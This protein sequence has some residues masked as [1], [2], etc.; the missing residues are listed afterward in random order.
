MTTR[1]HLLQSVSASAALAAI[2][3]AVAAAQTGGVT[4]VPGRDPI[5]DPAQSWA[6][7]RMIAGRPLADTL[8]FGVGYNWFDHLGAGGFY[9]RS[10]SYPLDRQ[11]YPDL[12][13]EEAWGQIRQA[14]DE[15]R[16]GFI[17]FGLPPDAHVAPDGSFRTGTVHLKRLAWLDAWARKNGCTI[18]LDPFLI[19]A[20][21]EFPP[22][23]GLAPAAMCNMAARDNTAYAERFVAPLLRHVV[24]ELALESV[25]YFN[26]VNEPL[27]Y[28]VYQTPRDGPDAYRHYVD[29]Y[30]AMRSALD[31]A[32]VARD[33]LGLVGCD[34]YTQRW[35]F[36]PEQ[37]ARG[38]DIDPFVDVYSIHFYSLRFDTL[39]ASEGSWTRPIV[40]LMEDSARQVRY[41]AERKKR[42]IA[43]EMGTFYYGWRM[44]DPAGVAS[45]DGT[46][47]VA[48]GVVRGMNA[49]LGAFGFWSFMNPNDIDG[50][51]GI[52]GL[53]HD[54]R[55]VRTAHPWGTYGLLSRY[56]RPGSTVYPLSEA[57]G[58]NLVP[59]HGTALVAPTGEKTI[60]L[61]HDEPTKRCRVDLVLPEPLRAARWERLTTDRVRVHQRLPPLE[62]KDPA[63]PQVVLNPFSLTVLTA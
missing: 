24:K 4:P 58:R 9:A 20:A 35:L 49:G 11:I 16:P 41:C 40:D 34:T 25:R 54:R 31:R 14:L 1:R 32:G 26:P 44:N 39:P 15:M 61:V 5:D 42:L 33:R 29:M 23:A 47:T 63:L 38:L 10:N 57:A 22:P 2:G 60:L 3:P 56:A 37:A 28:G 21:Y 8:A 19:P 12:A 27:E 45:P 51:F 7:F 46:L 52:V 13:D 53:D 55:L 43:A 17:R 30:R 18:L 59:V 62:P 36:L 48:E 6:S 50:W